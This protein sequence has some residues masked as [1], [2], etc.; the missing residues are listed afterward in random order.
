MSNV[1]GMPE[2][3]E[4]G[5]KGRDDPT[6]DPTRTARPR[7]M[8]PK[9]FRNLATGIGTCAEKSAMTGAVRKLAVEATM[10]ARQR[11]A[12]PAAEGYGRMANNLDF[13]DSGYD[14]MPLTGQGF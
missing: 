3:A 8:D 1:R 6:D 12:V 5:L 13:A 7:A 2:P 9:L 4:P 14:D 10:P 11:A